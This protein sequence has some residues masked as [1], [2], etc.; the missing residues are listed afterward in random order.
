MEQSSTFMRSWYLKALVAAVVVVA[1]FLLWRGSLSGEGGTDTGGIDHRKVAMM[2]FPGVELLDFAG[3]GEVFAATHGTFGRPTFE[4]FTVGLTTE[5]VISQGFVAITPERKLTADLE[6][7]IVVIPGGD[8]GLLMESPLMLSWLRD[9]LSKGATLLSVCN[10]ALVLAE[11][12]L[13]EGGEATTHHGAIGEL[14]RMAPRT[15]VH[16]DRRV[17]DNGRVITAAGISAGIDGALYV[18]A[19]LK[20]LATAS[21]VAEYM[22]YDG[23]KNLEP[24]LVKLQSE[25]GTVKSIEGR[26]WGGR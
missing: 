23:W 6:A 3:P 26:V 12:G 8:V 7:D 5:R 9:R 16:S 20:G 4:V 17:V 15:K 10:G 18:V 21:R 14:R 22:E 19:K 25:T 2:V 11:A 13:L 1:G 24:Q